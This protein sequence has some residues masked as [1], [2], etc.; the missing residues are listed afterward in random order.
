MNTI[1]AVAAGGALGA[2]ARYLLTGAIAGWGATLPGWGAAMGTF[3]VNAIGCFLMGLAVE[4]LALRWTP[5]PEMRAFLTAGLLGGFTTFST[6]ALDAALLQRQ[7]GALAFAYVAGSVLAG[8]GG[9]WL[10]MAAGRRFFGD[11][12]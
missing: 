1:L 6:F 4:T 7:G 11:A 3:A 9:L 10:G 8:L 12:A 5:S 2:S